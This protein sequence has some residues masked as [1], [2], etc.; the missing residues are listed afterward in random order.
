MLSM[1]IDFAMV[2]IILEFSWVGSQL[3]MMQSMS[4][5]LTVFGAI[6]TAALLRSPAGAL[7]AWATPLSGD[8]AGLIGM[9]LVGTGVGF[10]LVSIARWYSSFVR[11]ETV[12]LVDPYI[13]ALWGAGLGAV[14]AGISV[15]L[16][17]LVPAE[18]ALTS[19]A[20]TS[21]SGR[22]MV[23]FGSPIVRWMNTS[24][25]SY[26]Q[27]LPKG[28]AGAQTKHQSK[29]SMSTTSEPSTVPDAAGQ[30]VAELNAWRIRTGGLPYTWNPEI[31]HAA[32]LHSE[33]MME[34]R[35]LDVREHRGGASVA[36]GASFARRME[37]AI[38]GNASRYTTRH[39]MVVWAHSPSHAF[40]AIT[41]QP[42]LR[43][44]LADQSIM[45]IG[46][47]AARAGWFNG[48]MFTV[49]LVGRTRASGAS[50]NP[51]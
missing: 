51:R 3:G 45:E 34:E 41:S 26:T 47:G 7:V 50:T 21:R 42:R 31:A 32:G 38:G 39:V 14:L 11:D 35:F 40:R 6:I 25:P 30:L 13:G 16:L 10:G 33:M 12:R 18:G 1:V 9:V 24:F 2:A 4:R 8:M 23:G 20:I 44:A 15:G 49:G 28:A 29:L 48:T 27:T 19:G 43:A 37:L 22:V 17:V 5:T 36:S 46:I